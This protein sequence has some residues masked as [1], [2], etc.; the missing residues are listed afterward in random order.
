MTT[1]KP[2]FRMSAAGHCPKALSAELLHYDH[3]PVPD[4]LESAA[5]EGNWHEKRIKE[6]L[7]Q[8]GYVITGEQLELEKEF[9]TFILTGHIDGLIRNSHG[10]KLL[11]IKSMSQFEFD[12]WMR[13]NFSEFPQYQAQIACYMSV[14]EL[15]EVVYV[16]KNRNNGYVDK[17]IFSIDTM[18]DTFSNIITQLAEITRYVNN[19]VLVPIEPDF[20]S[21][22]CKRCNYKHLCIKSKEDMQIQDEAAIK[23]AV[24]TWR[25]GKKLETEGK[26]LIDEAKGVLTEQLLASELE[27]FYYDD[28]AVSKVNVKEKDIPARV[29]PAYW[30]IKINDLKKDN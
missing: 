26:Q 21:L 19:N 25:K 27:K 16:V 5:E 10:I 2:I 6:Q 23:L 3:E 12:R 14:L 13:G 7:Q 29:Q 4:W 9:D 22:Q 15:K 11:E 20:S 24:D 28:L 18:P 30:F 8:A 1:N 17:Q